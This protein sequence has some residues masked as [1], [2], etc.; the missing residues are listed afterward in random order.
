MRFACELLNWERHQVLPLLS[1]PC[2]LLLNIVFFFLVSGYCERVWTGYAD[3][4]YAF[5]SLLKLLHSS[6]C[7]GRIWECHQSRSWAT[8]TRALGWCTKE[9]AGT[10]ASLLAVK[11]YPCYISHC[12]FMK[13]VGNGG[14]ES[15]V[16][17]VLFISFSMICFCHLL[18]LF[19]LLNTAL[20]IASPD[21][22]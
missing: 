19:L 10:S 18:V 14:W 8:I 3:V 6:F 11:S 17:A 13:S 7:S 5:K 1:S 4:M 16:T 12:I 15:V 20:F 21:T 22:S 2:R 9:R